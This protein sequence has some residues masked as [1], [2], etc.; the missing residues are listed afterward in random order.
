MACLTNLVEDVSQVYLIAFEVDLHTVR[1]FQ[2]WRHHT[3][4]HAKSQADLINKT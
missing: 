2:E 3:Q 4:A 1:A